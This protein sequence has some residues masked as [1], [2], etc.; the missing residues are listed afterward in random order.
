M[1]EWMLMG[2]LGT[3]EWTRLMAVWKQG[4][5]LSMMGER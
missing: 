3:V 2:A 4:N 1:M 5:E